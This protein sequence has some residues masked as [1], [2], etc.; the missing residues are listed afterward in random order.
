MFACKIV[1][2][3]IYLPLCMQGWHFLS[4]LGMFERHNHNL[5][6]GWRRINPKN[7]G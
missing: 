3:S 4:L 1:Y 7:V 2:M 5:C 6:Y